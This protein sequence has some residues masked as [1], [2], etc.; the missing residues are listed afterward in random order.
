M[1]VTRCEKHS[2]NQLPAIALYAILSLENLPGFSICLVVHI[3]YALLCLVLVHFPHQIRLSALTVFVSVFLVCGSTYCYSAAQSP[4][5]N[6]ISAA[7]SAFTESY[8]WPQFAPTNGTDTFAISSYTI[9]AAL[10]MLIRVCLL[11][12]QECHL[13]VPLMT[14]TTA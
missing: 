14:P 11:Y 6:A 9:A 8:A 5:S 13:R 10:S 2:T 4:W 7:L 3:K 1:Y 12:S